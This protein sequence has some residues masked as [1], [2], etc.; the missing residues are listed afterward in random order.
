MRRRFN[1]PL[2]CRK[3]ALMIYWLDGSDC[4]ENI[5]HWCSL[6]VEF[7]EAIE[8]WIGHNLNLHQLAYLPTVRATYY[9]YYMLSEYLI[10]SHHMSSSQY[11]DFLLSLLFVIALTQVDLTYISKEQNCSESERVKFNWMELLKDWLL[12]DWLNWYVLYYL[13]PTLLFGRLRQALMVMP[14]IHW[15]VIV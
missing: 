10:I 3:L 1:N 9:Y 6:F 7:N 11:V 8:L 5:F 2:D 14:T 12:N 4:D 13:G 15:W